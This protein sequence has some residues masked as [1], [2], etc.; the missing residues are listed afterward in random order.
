MDAMT[1]APGDYERGGR[2]RAVYGPEDVEG[3]V[4]PLGAEKA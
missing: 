2:P 4:C 1:T 3:V